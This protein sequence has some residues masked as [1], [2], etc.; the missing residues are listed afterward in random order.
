LGYSVCYVGNRVEVERNPTMRSGFVF[1]GEP[2]RKPRFYFEDAGFL[3]CPSP[4][5]SPKA[6]E[7][8]GAPAHFASLNFTDG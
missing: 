7:K 6:G 2:E 4:I 5:L 8:D 1:Q 3:S